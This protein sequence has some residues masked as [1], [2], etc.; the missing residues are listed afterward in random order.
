[1]LRF[2]FVKLGESL[3]L[4]RFGSMELNQAFA[5]IHHCLT[6][7]WSFQSRCVV[8]VGIFYFFMPISF[9]SGL[10][11]HFFV[12]VGKCLVMLR[13]FRQLTQQLFDGRNIGP[14]LGRNSRGEESA[15]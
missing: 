4:L 1:M 10:A 7:S 15:Q 13:F 12:V 6:G 14:S 8:P 11:R 9:R 5:M 2:A 3:V